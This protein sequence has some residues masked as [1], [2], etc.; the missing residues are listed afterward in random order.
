MVGAAANGSLTLDTPGKF[1]AVQVLT[2]AQG[3][4]IGTTWNAT[5]NFSDG[6]QTVETNITDPDWT[7]TTSYDALSN[8]APSTAT[9]I[10]ASTS[11]STISRSRL[12]IK[13]RRSIRLR[14]TPSARPAPVLS[15]SR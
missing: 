4:G 10:P 5:L 6:S 11:A 13:P 7:L 14:S 8:T 15:S 1:Q 9:F 12:P 2:S 3:G